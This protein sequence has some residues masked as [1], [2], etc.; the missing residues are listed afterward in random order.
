MTFTRVGKSYEITLFRTFLRT[1]HGTTTGQ[2][3]RK[4]PRRFSVCVPYPTIRGLLDPLTLWTVHTR[5]P[6]PSRLPF[7]TVYSDPSVNPQSS[8]S[9]NFLVGDP[10]NFETKSN[11]SA[12]LSYYS[13]KKSPSTAVVILTTFSVGLVENIH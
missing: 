11:Q 7:T 13:K 6:N 8:I 4:E 9:W 10:I 12:S 2:S 5:D 3:G 1:Y